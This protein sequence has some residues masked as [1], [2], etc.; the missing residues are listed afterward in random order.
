MLQEARDAICRQG[1]LV[2]AVGFME[3]A[4]QILATSVFFMTSVYE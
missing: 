4:A 3:S 2:A 1:G